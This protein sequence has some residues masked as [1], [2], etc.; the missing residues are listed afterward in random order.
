MVTKLQEVQIESHGPESH[1]EATKLVQTKSKEP[2]P[3]IEGTKL[4]AEVHTEDSEIHSK[5]KEVVVEKHVRMCHAP[6]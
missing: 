5:T 1:L 3:W 2:K 4:E 6:N